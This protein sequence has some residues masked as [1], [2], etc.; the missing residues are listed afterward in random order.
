VCFL[1]RHVALSR[2][3]DA[4][5]GKQGGLLQKLAASL[6]KGVSA[7]ATFAAACLLLCNRGPHTSEIAVHGNLLSWSLHRRRHGWSG[8]PRP[9]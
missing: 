2:D 6:L 7:A 1:H 4:E 3:Q 8:A 9:A 5:Q